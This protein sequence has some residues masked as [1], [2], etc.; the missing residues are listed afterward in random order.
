M[1]VVRFLAA[2]TLKLQQPI[3]QDQPRRKTY[4]QPRYA[5]RQR[6]SGIQEIL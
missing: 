4:V 6:Y 2:G 3:K 5:R 1:D